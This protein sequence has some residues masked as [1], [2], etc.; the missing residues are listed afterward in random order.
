MIDFDAH[1][2]RTN[3]NEYRP[4][5]QDFLDDLVVDELRII[6]GLYG[7][8]FEVVRKAEDE[9]SVF[10]KQLRINDSIN[11][12]DLNLLFNRYAVSGKIELTIIT[13]DSLNSRLCN[14]GYL[15]KKGYDRFIRCGVESFASEWHSYLTSILKA[16]DYLR[17]KDV[18][19]KVSDDELLKYFFN[20]EEEEFSQSFNE[21]YAKFYNQ[22]LFG[23]RKDLYFEKFIPINVSRIRKRAVFRAVIEKLYEVKLTELLE[24]GE[25]L[26]EL[27]KKSIFT[28]KDFIQRKSVIVEDVYRRYVF[29][30]EYLSN[31][32]NSFIKEKYKETEG[33]MK[34]FKDSILFS[35]KDYNLIQ[36]IDLY[37]LR[38]LLSFDN[39]EIM[40]ID[41]RIIDTL[42]KDMKQINKRM[43]E[44]EKY[45]ILA[46]KELSNVIPLKSWL[47]IFSKQGV[48]T[49]G[50]FFELEFVGFY[51]L[52]KKDF[53]AV[54]D[55]WNYINNNL[56][57]VTERTYLS[58]LDE[59]H[60]YGSYLNVK[61]E[62]EHDAKTL[63]IFFKI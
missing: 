57:I 2:F 30:K 21:E 42:Y 39:K 18:K 1:K 49:T 53:A 35:D 61:I 36:I 10:C 48:K 20:N 12:H 50:D 38:K 55:L 5:H 45:K 7:E 37:K 13:D 8:L 29:L 34:H 44:Y 33:S 15:F 14:L 32:A 9:Y 43:N 26:T 63:D 19:A 16:V 41:G 52:C 47:L 17:V 25:L 6:Y 31:F 3:L 56:F 60:K 59:F 58:F 4:T 51:K 46:S 27:N 23:N 22:Y 40:Y 28:F 54:M 24:P 62:N 11:K